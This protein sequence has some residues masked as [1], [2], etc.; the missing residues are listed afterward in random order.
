MENM[1]NDFQKEFL[2]CVKKLY[3]TNIF[4]INK[5]KGAYNRKIFFTQKNKFA[6]DLCAI[7][8]SSKRFIYILT[9]WPNSQYDA[10]IYFSTN[11]QRYLENYFAF[12]KYILGNAIFTN[13][14][15]LISFYKLPLTN[16]KKYCYFNQKFSRIYINIKH[17]FENF[18]GQ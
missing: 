11:L 1:K 4:L 6:L 13:I 12:G 7:Y 15:H 10:K 9:S 3:G 2:G 17:V 16:K 5:P 14:F 18:K 8:N